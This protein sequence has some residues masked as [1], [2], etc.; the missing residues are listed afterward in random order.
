[1]NAM[2][3][4]NAMNPVGKNSRLDSVKEKFRAFGSL[5]MRPV[6]GDLLAMFRILFGALMAYETYR[7]FQF[8]R[9]TRYY[10]EPVYYFTYELF[11][12]V[13]P[14]PEP[15]MHLH[16]WL[17]G[18]AAVGVMLGL[19]YRFSIYLFFLT[20]TY[21]FLLDKAQYNNHYYLIILV[22]FL[23]IFMDAHK[24]A[25]IDRWRKGWQSHT[26]PFWTVFVLRAQIVIV[27]FY[28]GVAK[29]NEDWLMGEPIGTWLKDRSHYPVVGEFFTTDAA[30][31]FFGYGGLLFDLFIGF[32]LLW[33][34]TR[35]LS[36]GP[37]LF[38]HLTNK[39][40]F[41]IG[42]FPYMMIAVTLIFFEPGLPRRLWHLAWAFIAKLWPAAAKVKA[43]SAESS[44]STA[45]QIVAPSQ[46]AHRAWV[47]GFVGVF[48]ALQILLPLRHWL[49]PG[50]VS[51]T[52][53]G[54]RFSWH[55]KLRTKSA[56]TVFFVTDPAT[57]QTW[58]IDTSNVLTDRQYDKMSNR[59]DMILQ[60]AHAIR[61]QFQRSGRIENPIV[62]VDSW[63]SLNG[64][65]TQQL[66][67][68]TV[69]LAQEPATIFG[70]YPWVLPLQERPPV[71]EPLTKN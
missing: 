14:W 4:M 39:W 5:L 28:G 30:T 51:W 25:S 26:V 22:A 9:I 50:E 55:M 62:R 65:P 35:L 32:L 41:N 42:I 19:Y 20:Y 2:D 56:I 69:D 7:Y 37:L 17:M 68:P 8:D 10:V 47:F 13:S 40:L 1:M 49:Y 21:V 46:T 29:L 43:N 52:E 60:F 3:P 63:A 57:G 12:M 44:P 58:E 23:L 71:E 67:D 33:P 66:I 6:D 70:H 11:P 31:Y 18:L 24:V 53:E 48:L 16:F 64:R 61:D 34:R 36:L 27:Y 45:L 54:H 15:W 59:P 38:F